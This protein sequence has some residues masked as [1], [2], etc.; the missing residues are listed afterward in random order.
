MVVAVVKR[1]GR[2]RRWVEERKQTTRGSRWGDL[3]IKGDAWLWR[4]KH[5]SMRG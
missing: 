4:G 3:Q 1:R 2:V 5:N